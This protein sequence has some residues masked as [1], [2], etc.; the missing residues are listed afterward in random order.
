MRNAYDT[1][2]RLGLLLAIAGAVNWLLVGLFEWNAIQWIFTQSGTQNV[3]DLGERIVYV[4]VG[5]GGVLAVPMLAATLARSRSRDVSSDER[6]HSTT[7]VSGDDTAFYYGAPKNDRELAREPQ[8]VRR[9]ERVVVEEP[10]PEPSAEARAADAG[11]QS[12]SAD[13]SL[14]YGTVEET[15]EGLSEGYEER[16]AA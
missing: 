7:E 1:I 8:H 16:R 15:D 6:V 4:V 11:S 5:V 2:G 13:E 9:I 12:R 3:D 10:V 14:R